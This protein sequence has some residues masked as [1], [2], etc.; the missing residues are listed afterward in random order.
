VSVHKVGVA[1]AE[2]EA[3]ERSVAMV[4]VIAR[5]VLVRFLVTVETV[6]LIISRALPQR[7]PVVVAAVATVR[8]LTVRVALAAAGLVVLPLLQLSLERQTLVRA[9]AEVVLEVMVVLEALA[10]SLSVLRRRTSLIQ[11]ALAA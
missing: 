9:E 10:L 5:K 3:P 4:L 8:A 11:V 7:T 2:A 1:A 6:A